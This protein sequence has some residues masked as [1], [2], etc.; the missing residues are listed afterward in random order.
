MRSFKPATNSCTLRLRPVAASMFRSSHHII[1]PPSREDFFHL[2]RNGQNARQEYTRRSANTP[3]IAQCDAIASCH[4]R[5]PNALFKVGSLGASATSG[6]LLLLC[7]REIPLI[8]C[9][10]QITPLLQ[11]WKYRGKRSRSQACSSRLARW[12]VKYRRPATDRLTARPFPDAAPILHAF[13]DRAASFSAFIVPA[14][15][16]RRAVQARFI[17]EGFREGARR[18]RDRAS[19]RSSLTRLKPP[20]QPRR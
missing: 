3:W 19:D 16:L 10:R 15:Q 7:A 8:E 9:A 4:D 2:A 1:R 5:C 6:Y 20:R 11:P 17:R 14:L 18:K 12:A 13:F